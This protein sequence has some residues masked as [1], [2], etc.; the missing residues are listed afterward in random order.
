M[1]GL[2]VLL[3]ILCVWAFSK[4]HTPLEY[5]V[6]GTLG[7]SILLAGAFVQIVRRGYLRDTKGRSLT[8]RRS[9]TPRIVRGNEQ[10][11]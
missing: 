8:I 1:S 11:S 2:A 9:V 3:V 5:M 7:T 10:S 6:G 4:P